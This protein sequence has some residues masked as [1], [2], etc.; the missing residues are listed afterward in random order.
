MGLWRIALQLLVCLRWLIW[1][2]TRSLCYL[3]VQTPRPSGSRMRTCAPWGR[4]CDEGRRIASRPFCQGNSMRLVHS[5]FLT[6]QTCCYLCVSAMDWDRLKTLTQTDRSQSRCDPLQY[7]CTVS[8]SLRVKL[9]SQLWASVLRTC[10]SCRSHSPTRCF[11]RRPCGLRHPC[12]FIAHYFEWSI[13][14]YSCFQSSY[15]IVQRLPLHSFD[16]MSWADKS[17]YCKQRNLLLQIEQP[18]K[19]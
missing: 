15:C 19:P 12:H 11:Q 6:F 3:T 4:R 13:S 16:L 1:L 8:A 2:S 9:A 10:S 18:L 17:F 7:S 5:T 14:V